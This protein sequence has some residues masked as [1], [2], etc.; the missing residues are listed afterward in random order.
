MS[1]DL[2]MEL[3]MKATGIMGGKMDKAFSHIQMVHSMMV[4]VITDTF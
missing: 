4:Q 1:T 3:F 2:P